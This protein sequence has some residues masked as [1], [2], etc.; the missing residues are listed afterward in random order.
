[1]TEARD[2]A[3]EAFVATVTSAR[4]A[5][6][7]T[8]GAVLGI[9]WATVE[10]ERAEREFGGR[11]DDAAMDEILGATCRTRANLVL[12]EPFTEGPLSAT[13]ARH[14]EGPV[15]VWFDDVE[16]RGAPG[17]GRELRSVPAAGPFGPERLVAGS[18]RFGPHVFLVTPSPGT[19]PP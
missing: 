6:G 15:A 18:P 17:S 4:A 10:L 3:L 2:A 5:Q 16:E 1:M 7:L 19:I 14:G 13:L 9:G 11:F 8:T 12:I